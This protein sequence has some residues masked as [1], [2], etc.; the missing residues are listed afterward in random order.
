MMRNQKK[1][2]K[3]VLVGT[4]AEVEAKAKSYDARGYHTDIIPWLDL[5]TMEM[6]GDKY[7]L[8]VRKVNIADVQVQ[9]IIANRA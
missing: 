1:N 2:I 7:G 9:T 3:C 8:Y 5:A 4:K 6:C